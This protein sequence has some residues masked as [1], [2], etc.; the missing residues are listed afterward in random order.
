MGNAFRKRLLFYAQRTA[1][2]CCGTDHVMEHKRA[3]DARCICGDLAYGTN[4]Y[5]RE[6][7]AFGI[8]WR[9]YDPVQTGRSMIHRHGSTFSRAR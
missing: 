4:T 1:Q 3:A 6:N 7:A 2:S 8:R 5:R 9:I